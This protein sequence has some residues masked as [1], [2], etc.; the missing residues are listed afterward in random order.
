[1]QSYL[2][3]KFHLLLLQ[4]AY[5]LDFKRT[6]RTFGYSFVTGCGGSLLIAMGGT[7]SSEDAP[8]VSV[9]AWLQGHGARPGAGGA[10]PA[11]GEPTAAI[12]PVLCPHIS[13]MVTWLQD[14]GEASRRVCGKRSGTPE[15]GDLTEVGSLKSEVLTRSRV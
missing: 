3:G 10:R 5:S 14:V 4:E 1:M 15:P 8:G 9:C 2:A 12:P 13:T 7:G 11:T 6:L